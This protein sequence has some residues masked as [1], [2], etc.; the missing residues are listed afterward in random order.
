[1]H[2]LTKKT[3][4]KLQAGRI[5]AVLLALTLAAGMLAGCTGKDEDTSSGLKDKIKQSA[6]KEE[7]KKESGKKKK[8]GT[9]SGK[10]KKKEEET[11]KDAGV[12][13]L[14]HVYVSKGYDSSWD[15]ESHQMYINYNYEEIHLGKE[16]AGKYP[17]LEQKTALINDLIVTEE[18]NCYQAAEREYAALDIEAKD[19]G[20]TYGMLPYKQDWKAYVRR[21]DSDVFSV[22]TTAVTYSEID[23][24]DYRFVGYNFEPETGRELE[25]TDVVADMD[26]FVSRIADEVIDEM[27]AEIPDDIDYDK[28]DVTD[29]IKANL[30]EGARGNWT[31]EPAGVSVWFDSYTLLPTPVHFTL[32]FAED[33]D[34]SYFT[35]TYR[36]NAPENWTMALPLYI[37]EKFLSDDGKKPE[38][39]TV[40]ESYEYYEEDGYQFIEGIRTIYNGNEDIFVLG[41]DIYDTGATLIHQNGTNILLTKYSDYEWNFMDTF[42]LHAG[43]VQGADSIPGDVATISW[44]EMDPDDYSL[45][46][47]FLTDPT[48]FKVCAYTDTLSTCS[49]VRDCRLNDSGDFEMQEDYY[50]ITEDAQYEIKLKYD[51][52]GLSEV[53]KNTHEVMS[54]TVD[55]KAGDTFKLM[56][57]D[58]ET[59]A[60]GLTKDGTLVRIEVHVYENEGGRYV[61][62]DEGDFSIFEA[63]EDTM[64]A[65]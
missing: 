24:N 29:S 61:E 62:T 44:D 43:K 37:N 63:F 5:L 42:T 15:D 30:K 8:K 45:P 39:L 31:L 21:A 9:K 34:G 48:Q 60:D 12:S 26:A 52:S 13:P 4:R 53:D 10:E 46:T 16:S 23:Y 49:A 54:T 17:E 2:R 11:A 35:D 18:S 36:D 14:E 51:M 27:K 32:L 28:E 57:T 56:Y 3:G 38:Y 40:G 55:L 20:F 7:G 22:L 1:M 47:R 6:K 59:Y 58:D 25:L 65:G 19:D 33:E 50:T 41:D 64:F